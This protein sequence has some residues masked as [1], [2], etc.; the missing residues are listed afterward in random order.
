MA[1]QMQDLAERG[2]H[3][4][5]GKLLS[6]KMSRLQEDDDRTLLLGG[7]I[8]V[9]MVPESAEAESTSRTFLLAGM[10]NP[11]GAKSSAAT[12]IG[13]K[14][15]TGKRPA[16]TAP[17]VIGA[18]TF[19]NRKMPMDAKTLPASDIVLPYDTGS[20]DPEEHVKEEEYEDV[21]PVYGTPGTP[22]N[23][24]DEPQILKVSKGSVRSSGR[25]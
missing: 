15:A 24:F 16:S 13:N 14:A 19:K 1:L 12:V 11:I 2:N 7:E 25:R 21:G 18:S 23:D 4:I 17:T 8:P 3:E 22:G 6:A 5:A 20:D 9:T 10:S